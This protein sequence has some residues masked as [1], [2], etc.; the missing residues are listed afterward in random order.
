MIEET[1]K[2]YPEGMGFEGEEL[3]EITPEDLPHQ[4]TEES[5]EATVPEITVET[6]PEVTAPESNTGVSIGYGENSNNELEPPM[7]DSSDEF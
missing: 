7:V 1:E 2:T 3:E 6:V 4:E 5:T